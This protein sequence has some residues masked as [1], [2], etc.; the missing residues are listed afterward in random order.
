ADDLAVDSHR[1]RVSRS[2]VDD[3]MPDR[4][5]SFYSADRARQ[6]R[7]V[8]PSLGD[9]ELAV[10]VD[11]VILIDKAQLEGAR[12]GV[13]DEYAQPST[14]ARSNGESPPRP[15]RGPWSTPGR[16]AGHRPPPDERG[17]PPSRRTARV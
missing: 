15:G 11:A 10:E 9:L 2:S 1:R 7:L 12:P 3:A 4:C 13:E 17:R 8:E 6:P 5:D 16:L 14:A